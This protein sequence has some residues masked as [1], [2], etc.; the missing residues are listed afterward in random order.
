M[1]LISFL[2]RLTR[3]ISLFHIIL[4]VLS[5]V[6]YYSRSSIPK[7]ATLW[8]L[9]EDF[10][11]GKIQTIL[12]WYSILSRWE[13][14]ELGISWYECDDLMLSYYIWT[15]LRGIWKI[16]V[17]LSKWCLIFKIFSLKPGWRDKS[18]CILVIACFHS[19]ILGFSD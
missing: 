11:K 1:P 15:F 5:T 12:I 7:A 13:F 10:I 8:F 4:E 9:F 2:V 14:L 16:L 19:S 6:S 3:N 17:K 18:H